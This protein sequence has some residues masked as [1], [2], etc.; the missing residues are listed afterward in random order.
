M[1]PHQEIHGARHSCCG[2]AEEAEAA[3][4][5][6]MEVGV[7]DQTNKRRSGR[8]GRCRSSVVAIVVDPQRVTRT[9][10]ASLDSRLE[11]VES[12]GGG[13]VP[14]Y[15]IVHCATSPGASSIQVGDSPV[16]VG[17]K[18]GVTGR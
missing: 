6:E 8:E 11:E 2:D 14:T 4:A 10:N 17:G 3:E 7:E 15:T 5:A 16:T 13:Q 12:L 18:E 1:V 9:A